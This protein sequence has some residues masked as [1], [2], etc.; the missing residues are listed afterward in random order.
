VPT[1][2][3]EI[4]DDDRALFGD[5]SGLIEAARTRAAVAV[6]SE[7]VMLYWGIGKR[8]R[9][10]ILGGER[11]EYGQ[12][13]VK[14]LA[15]RLTERYG[16]G[17]TYTN[18]TRMLKF[19]ESYPDERIVAPVAQQLPW[20]SICIALGIPDQHKR[21]FYLTF[22]THERWSKRTLRAKIDDKL[23]ERTIEARGG[24]NG[25]EEELAALRNTGCAP[26]LVFREPYILDFLGLPASHSE[27]ELE[28]AI[29]DDMWRFIIELGGGFAFVARQKRITVDGDDYYLDLLFYHLGMRCFVAV[30]LKTRKLQPADYG[31]MLLY[32]RWLDANERGT[33]DEAP[34]GLILCASKGPQQTKLL[35]LDDGEIRAARYI[36]E[37]LRERMQRRLREAVDALEE[38]LS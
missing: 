15:E 27:A 23:Y 24:V 30:E 21:D 14:R 31:Q 2:L 5:V 25:L 29:L 36:T 38:G 17:Y 7:L 28:R 10:D 11:A 12:A 16:R 33:A 35:G 32:L 22:A 26:G 6:N 8:I 4:P 37:P 34:V 18:L 1:E 13:V 9:E 3:L 20:T 19:V